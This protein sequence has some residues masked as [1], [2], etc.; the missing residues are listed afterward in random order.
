MLHAMLRSVLR[1]AITAASLC[2]AFDA[3]AASASDNGPSGRNDEAPASPI[4]WGVRLNGGVGGGQASP[5]LGGFSARAGLDG[6]YWFS[7]L[8]AIGAQIGWQ[9]M[10]SF[11]YLGPGNR[12]ITGTADVY[13]LAPSVTLRGSNPRNFPIVS[14][15]AGVALVR[16]QWDQYCD[17]A[18]FGSSEACAGSSSDSL[19]PE[20]YGSVTVGWLF[21]PGGVAVGPMFRFDAFAGPSNGFS[22]FTGL[23]IG[24]G[25]APRG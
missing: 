3:R 2:F 18:Y 22:Y 20:V 8:L 25:Y 12:D 15:A 9:R 13:S 23:Q 17:P 6:E 7:K 24:F 16:S 10:A 1:A 19:D 21:H 4:E 5:M 14:L 11:A